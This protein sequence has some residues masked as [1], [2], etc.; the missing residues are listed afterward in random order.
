MHRRNLAIIL[1]L[2]AAGCSSPAATEPTKLKVNPAN[3]VVTIK[4]PGM[5]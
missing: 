2:V 4:V 1:L 3:E 5:T